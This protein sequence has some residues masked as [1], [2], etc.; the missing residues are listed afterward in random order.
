[1]SLALIFLSR[2]LEVILW[3]LIILIDV[4]IG[5]DLLLRHMHVHIVNV[6]K[7]YLLFENIEHLIGSIIF[8]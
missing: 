1:M 5:V 7:R 8:S 6:F 2:V 4:W 3:N